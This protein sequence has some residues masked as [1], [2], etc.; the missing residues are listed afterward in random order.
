MQYRGASLY[1]PSVSAIAVRRRIGMVFQKPN[2]FPKWIYDNIAY[3]PRINGER[4]KGKLDE[5]SR[6]RCAR[7]RCGTR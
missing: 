2:P 5:M 3:G 7:P 1:A 4:N 6:N